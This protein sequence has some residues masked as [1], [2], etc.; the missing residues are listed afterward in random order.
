MSTSILAFPVQTETLC[1]S[2]RRPTHEDDLSSFAC[3]DARVCR[4]CHECDCDRLAAD[5][6]ARTMEAF[7]LK[8]R[9]WVGLAG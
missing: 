7:W 5:F 2:C 3:C 1:D 8:V 4:K 6:A 9:G